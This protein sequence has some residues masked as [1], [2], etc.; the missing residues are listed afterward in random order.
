MKKI[1]TAPQCDSTYVVTCQ[2]LADSAKQVTTNDEGTEVSK[3][4]IKNT[5]TEFWI[6]AKQNNGSIW[7]E[8]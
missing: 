4:D 5:D 6:G 3:D 2:P 1:Y 7:D 8:E